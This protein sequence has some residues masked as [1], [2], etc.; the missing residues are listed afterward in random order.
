MQEISLILMNNKGIFKMF[1]Y[2]PTTYIYNKH[3]SIYLEFKMYFKIALESRSKTGS[4]SYIPLSF[5]Y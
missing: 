1:T 4:G 3:Y 2:T 5:F